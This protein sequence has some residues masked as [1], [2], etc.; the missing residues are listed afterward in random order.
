MNQFAHLKYFLN[1]SGR[2]DFP[3]IAIT[4]SGIALGYF[5]HTRDAAAYLDSLGG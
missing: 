2:K 4:A 5:K 1:Y 3:F